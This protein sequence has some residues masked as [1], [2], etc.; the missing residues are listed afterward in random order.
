MSIWRQVFRCDCGSVTLP[1]SAASGG[2]ALPLA[3]ITCCYWSVKSEYAF[4]SLKVWLDLVQGSTTAK[5]LVLCCV[6]GLNL[7]SQLF[8]SQEFELLSVLKVRHIQ[9]ET[10]YI[11]LL[12]SWTGSILKVQNTQLGVL[13]ILSIEPLC[14]ILFKRIR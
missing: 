9:A 1:R 14:K 12:F 2:A 10:L 5:R 13:C 11:C 6:A 3:L 7:C 8:T 4:S